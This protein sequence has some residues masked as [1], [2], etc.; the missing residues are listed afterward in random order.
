MRR[1]KFTDARPRYRSAEES[2]VPGYLAH[3]FRVYA[4]LARMRRRKNIIFLPSEGQSRMSKSQ[5]YAEAETAW[6]IALASDEAVR[7]LC[8]VA[9]ASAVRMAWMLGHC[10]GRIAGLTTAENMYAARMTQRDKQERHTGTAE[11]DTDTRGNPL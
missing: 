5:I 4:R 1:P 11:H 10:Q 3:R 8:T 7:A 6:A 9:E 2:K